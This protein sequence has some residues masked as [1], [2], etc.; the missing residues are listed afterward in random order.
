[1]DSADKNLLIFFFIVASI[2]M[3]GNA[4]ITFY[5]L[6]FSAMKAVTTYVIFLIHASAF[7]QNVAALPVVYNGNSGMCEFMAAAHYYAGLVNIGATFLLT[8]IYYLYTVEYDVGRLRFINNIGTKILLAGPVIVVLPFITNSYGNTGSVWCSIAVSNLIANIWSFIVFYIWV[9][10]LLIV[11]FILLR[12]IVY[13]STKHEIGIR[14]RLF[15]SLG[16]YILITLVC[17]LPRII[18]HIIGLIFE[19]G[20]N[21][22]WQIVLE[23]S[24]YVAGILYVLCFYFNRRDIWFYESKLTEEISDLAALE[25]SFEDLKNMLTSAIDEESQDR[26]ISQSVDRHSSI[27]RQSSNSRPSNIFSLS[28]ASSHEG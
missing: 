18:P 24:I 6:R 23:I 1:M 21:F 20:Y 14:G 12:Y 2:S 4:F 27:D 25:V 11:N 8:L 10:I 5:F 26:K 17:L 3:F 9:I 13:Y 22:V 28:I 15:W 19:I 16:I 7:L